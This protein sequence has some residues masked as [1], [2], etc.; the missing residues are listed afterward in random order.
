MVRDR[1]VGQDLICCGRI[2][3]GGYVWAL[4][5]SHVA[6]LQ[7]LYPTPPKKCHQSPAAT[8]SMPPSQEHQEATPEASAPAMI[9][10]E[11]ALEVPS[12]AAPETAEEAIPAHMTSLH[13]QLGGV[14]RVY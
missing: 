8:V 13:L 12:P 4:V 11:L 10:S 5:R 3:D 6:F 7:V 14:K 9:K 1:R 2:G